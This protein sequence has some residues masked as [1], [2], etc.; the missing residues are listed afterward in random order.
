MRIDVHAHLRTDDYL[1][2]LDSYGRTDTA[3]QRG[4]ARGATERYGLSDW[5]SAVIVEYG[6]AYASGWGDYTTPDFAQVVGRPARSFADFARDHG[7][8][9]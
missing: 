5:V 4:T 3:T 8:G 2:L 7:L 9:S 1:D 6:R